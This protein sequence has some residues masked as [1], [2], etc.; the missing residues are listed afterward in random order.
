MKDRVEKI[1][2]IN[3]IA[4]FY[5]NRN[6]GNMRKN[7]ELISFLMQQL[8]EA[9]ESNA[10]IKLEDKVK[11]YYRDL[12]K[13]VKGY[14]RVVRGRPEINAMNIFVKEAQPERLT[15]LEVAFALK[16]NAEKTNQLLE[17]A[18]QYPLHWGGDPQE[19]VL[20]FCL[21]K[22]MSHLDAIKMYERFCANLPLMSAEITDEE[23]KSL[24]QRSKFVA[25]AFEQ[26]LKIEDQRKSLQEFEKQ[27]YLHAASYSYYSGRI[28][29]YL[30]RLYN[31][32]V[33]NE[34][35]SFYK[36][37]HILFNRAKSGIKSELERV[38]I[39]EESHPTREFVYM[40]LCVDYY[41]NENLAKLCSLEEYVNNHLRDEFGL[42]ELAEDSIIE[43]LLI[44]LSRYNFS[45][46]KKNLLTYGDSWVIYTEDKV[47][48]RNIDKAGYI[49]S[50]YSEKLKEKGI[51]LPIEDVEL[52]R[53]A[54]FIQDLFLKT[55]GDK[56]K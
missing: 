40:L 16:M 30:L 36:D 42:D 51:D 9:V 34:N 14:G 19:S 45:K 43:A 3:Q 8:N 50:L 52:I 31:G 33:E 2:V 5:N 4:H 25:Q 26:A 48:A 18:G 54:S 44:E 20:Y 49:L 11:E 27:L 6:N 37:F 32:Q 7:G 29:R 22:G 41:R 15:L 24:S 55:P 12:D 21:E 56:K 23:I 13:Q 28:R 35:N 53:K 47:G 1:S 39:K 38:V 10:R 17:I 46:R